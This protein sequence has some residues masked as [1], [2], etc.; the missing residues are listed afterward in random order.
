MPRTSFEETQL[1]ARALTRFELFEFS[2]RDEYAAPSDGAFTIGRNCACFVSRRMV[3]RADECC[4]S[5]TSFQDYVSA[6][7][8]GEFAG[9]H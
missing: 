1:E 7:F 4:L 8:Q 3:F 6:N 5:R 2:R 9:V